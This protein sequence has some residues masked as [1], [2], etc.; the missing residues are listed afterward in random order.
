MKDKL[1]VVIDGMSADPEISQM[2]EF[3]GI[4]TAIVNLE[5][6]QMFDNKLAYY[7][8]SN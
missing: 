4:I 2:R 5:R 3:H 1:S 7:K 6:D 8:V